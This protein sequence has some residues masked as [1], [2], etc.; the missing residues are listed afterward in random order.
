MWDLAGSAPYRTEHLPDPSVHL[1]VEAADS[2][3]FGPARGRFARLVEGAGWSFCIKFRPGGFHPFLC[4][5]VA[6]LKNKT[7]RPGEVFGVAGER[8]ESAMRAAAQIEERLQI[9]EE[10]LR[11][12]R[13]ER[14]EGLALIHRIIARI[15]NGDAIRRS[16]QLEQEFNLTGRTLQRLFRRYVGASPSWVIRRYRIHEAIEQVERGGIADWPGLAADLGYF[17]QAHFIKDFK[18]MTGLSPGN[19]AR[20]VSPTAHNT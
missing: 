16:R 12:R 13:P 1:I 19:Y 17:D 20:R 5:P 15:E 3:I 18:R 11:S 8:L 4:S 9:A 2:G 14:E 7:L 6:G 10:F